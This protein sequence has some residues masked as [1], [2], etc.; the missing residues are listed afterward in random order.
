MRQRID[1]PAKTRRSRGAERAR[2]NLLNAFIAVGVSITV[3][4]IAMGA[5]FLYWTAA[6][7]SRWRPV[8]EKESR[9]GKDRIPLERGRALNIGGQGFAPGSKVNVQFDGETV[10]EATADGAGNVGLLLDVPGG[11]NPG[12]HAVMLRGERSD[13][14]PLNLLT[15][16]VLEPVSYSKAGSTP[17]QEIAFMVIERTGLRAGVREGGSWWALAKG[18]VRVGSTAPVG[19]RGTTLIVG[20]GTM[21]GAPFGALSRLRRNDRVRIYTD[22]AVYV[23]EVVGERV[24]ALDDPGRLEKDVEPTLALSAYNPAGWGGRVVLAEL[25]EAFAF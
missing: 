20:H 14:A 1:K 4:P 25:K 18:P 9:S 24:I 3:L 7:E 6:S 12:I 15:N 17:G 2:R 19:A 10:R 23:Y 16:T 5:F 13:G 22:E 11:A 21:F 8:V